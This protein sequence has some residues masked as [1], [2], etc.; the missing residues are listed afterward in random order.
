MTVFVN[1]H[2]SQLIY[3]QFLGQS[4]F[5]ASPLSD[6]LVSPVSMLSAAFLKF[7]YQ[8]AQNCKYLSIEGSKVNSIVD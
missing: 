8:G 7:F 5:A 4:S 3:S 6:S 2:R 1:E